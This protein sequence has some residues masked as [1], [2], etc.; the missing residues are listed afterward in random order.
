MKFMQEDNVDLNKLVDKKAKTDSKFETR[1][2]FIAYCVRKE[3][4]LLKK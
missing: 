3:L 2:D 4:G 1:E